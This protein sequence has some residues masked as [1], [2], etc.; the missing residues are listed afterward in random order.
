MNEVIGIPTHRWGE[1]EEALFVRLK[2]VDGHDIVVV[3]HNRPDGLKLP[4]PV[5][6]I[7]DE[8]VRE[9]RLRAVPDWGWRCGDYFYYALREAAPDKRFYWLIEPD[10]HFTEDPNDFFAAVAAADDYA[11]GIQPMPYDAYNVFTKGLPDIDHF[12][13]I[14]ALTRLSGKALDWLVG[15]RQ[16]SRMGRR[17]ARLHTNDELFV[18]FN[19]ARNDDQTVGDLTE[20]APNWFENVQFESD[21][22]LLV[23]VLPVSEGGR[24]YHPVRSRTAYCE[25][26]AA[27]LAAP[28]AF[29]P[30]SR[31]SLSRLND[32]EIETIVD[33]AAERFEKLLKNMRGRSP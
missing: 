15:E 31:N 32:E 30:K 6:D 8:W 24:V 18:F 2:C 25:A 11:L 20:L 16:T 29:L 4:L 9:K 14:F 28:P 33:L 19:C 10:V 26:I 3:F 1:E 22:D 21:P 17:R 13:A 5:V 7:S 12:R 27:R 23:D